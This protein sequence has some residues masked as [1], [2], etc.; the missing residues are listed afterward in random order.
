MNSLKETSKHFQKKPD[1]LRIN[2]PK[3]GEYAYLKEYLSKFKLHTICE[4]GNCPNIGECWENKTATFMILGD[5]CTRSCGFCAVKIGKPL[6]A[7]YEEP[8]RIAEVI[9]QMDLKHC[10]I[11]SVDRDDLADGG[12]EIWAMTIDAIKKLNPETTLEALIPDF[13]GDHKNLLTVIKSKPDILSHNLE[14]VERLTKKVRVQAQYERSLEVLEFISSNGITAKS[15]IMLGLGETKDEILQAMDDMLNAGCTILT[16]GQY[17]QPSKKHLAVERYIHP[18]EFEEFRLLAIQKG[19][20]FAESGPLVR[21]SYHAERHLFDKSI[22][23]VK[24]KTDHNLPL[25]DLL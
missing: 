6:P 5:I 8:G 7:D 11:T 18:D 15:G 24:T 13:K 1:W 12:A 2:L 20:V 22:E 3:A 14:T 4:S 17:L 16:L 21:S 25:T 19:F 23:S 10:V 9:K